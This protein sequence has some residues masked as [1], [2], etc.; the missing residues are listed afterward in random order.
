MQKLFPI[1]VIL[2]LFSGCIEIQEEIQ[3]KENRSGRL[4]YRLETNQLGSILTNL[5]G[6]LDN[7]LENQLKAKA[8]EIAIRMEQKEGI[9]D[10]EF[11]ID[12]RALNY[13]LACSFTDT[14]KLN[15]ALYDVFGYKKTLFSPGY[16]KVSRHTVKKIN[17]SPYLKQ[18]LDDEGI[19][20][21][22]GYLSEV[23]YFRS[24]IF[25]P[26]R[27]RRAKGAEV[28][29]IQDD[30]TVRQKFKLTEVLENE[31]DVGVKIKY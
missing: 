15:E 4:T 25:L 27:V 21:P 13:E 9:S 28:E 8:N 12:H 29:I 2:F 20:I 1:I 24:V 16:L 6:F 30:L 7:S 26:D 14:K 31:V 19:Y 11:N 17:F 18:Y 3:I 22:S 5:A 10:V 23:I